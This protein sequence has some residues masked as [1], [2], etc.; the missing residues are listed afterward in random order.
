[1]VAVA[2]G[3]V[4]L[5][6]V[7]AV[8]RVLRPGRLADRVVGLDVTLWGL[9]SLI[10]INAAATGNANFEDIPLIVALL[11]VLGT[12]TAAIWLESRGPRS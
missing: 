7:L 1:M 5:S 8:I 6:I 4:A 9:I 3:V 10:A 2:Y 11:G 12:V